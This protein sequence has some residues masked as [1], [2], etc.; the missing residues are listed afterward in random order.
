MRKS[1]IATWLLLGA[2]TIA[3]FF[4][5]I[6][7]YATHDDIVLEENV[8]YGNPDR[9]NGLTLDLLARRSIMDRY[10]RIA[11]TLGNPDSS[12]TIYSSYE[13]LPE[14]YKNHMDTFK[15]FNLRRTG[16]HQGHD[17]FFEDIYYAVRADFDLPSTVDNIFNEYYD[18]DVE[19]K[20]LAEQEL[21]LQNYFKIPRITV[22]ND[23]FPWNTTSIYSDT[24][25]YFTFDLHTEKGNIVDT[26]LLPDGFGI[27]AFPYEKGYLDENGNYVLGA[28]TS[29][30][31]MIY[32]LEPD[33]HIK[34]LCI[35]SSQK[36]LLLFTEENNHL[37]LHIIDIASRN[38]IKNL[39]L[40]ELTEDS[41]RD[42]YA[43]VID[44]AILLFDFDLDTISVVSSGTNESYN[45]DFVFPFENEYFLLTS[46]NQSMSYNGERLAFCDFYSNED[47]DLQGSD[48]YVAIY[49]KEG[50]TYFGTYRSSIFSG[51]EMSSLSGLYNCNWYKYPQISW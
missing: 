20:A 4:L 44:G 32:A 45:V 2:A 6:Q 33:T 9:A 29:K 26:S 40:H 28:D 24:M 14:E 41:E 18:S 50:L 43:H 46:L 11:Y 49:E 48:I 13:T 17:I 15:G 42:I 51:K 16:A 22:S 30:L 19:Q 8:I 25:C 38:E 36:H 23:N 3:S 5:A 47:L 34:N 27:F 39:E 37:K 31:E 12:E 35:D 21:F 1:Y 7:I 10:W